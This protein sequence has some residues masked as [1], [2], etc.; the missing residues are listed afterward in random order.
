MDEG[1]EEALA[2]LIGLAARPERRAEAPLHAGEDA[3]DLPA[4]SVAFAKEAAVH[5]ASVTGLGGALAVG[6]PV[7]GDH[8]GAN[9][10]RLTAEDVVVLRVV[11]GVGQ[12]LVERQAG[13]HL[14]QDFGKGPGVRAGALVDH[15]AHDEVAGGVHHRRE[16]RPAAAV[17]VVDGAG[18]A[19]VPVTDVTHLEPRRVDGGAGTVLDQADA[20]S[21]GD[22]SAQ[23]LGIAP[24]FVMR[25]CA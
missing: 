25:W 24:F 4:L 6:A 21:T 12:D 17:G 18:P 5:L 10:Q 7:E 13:D 11:S 8:G 3:L 16:F 22:E 20:E 15:R 23:E 9:P 2:V 14:A 19:A 1:P